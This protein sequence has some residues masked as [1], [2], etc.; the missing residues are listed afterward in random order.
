MVTAMVYSGDSNSNPIADLIKSLTA[1]STSP[2]DGQSPGQGLV[3]GREEFY[4]EFATK[5]NSIKT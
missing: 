3:A 1:D 5:H 2:K 4:P